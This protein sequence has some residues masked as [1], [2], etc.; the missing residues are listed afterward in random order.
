MGQTQGEVQ[1]DRQLIGALRDIRAELARI[2]DAVERAW[3]V[4]PLEQLDREL[5]R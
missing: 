3:P 5:R 1:R 4:P 2:A